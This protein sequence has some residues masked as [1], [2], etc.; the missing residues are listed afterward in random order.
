MFVVVALPRSPCLGRFRRIHL[1]LQIVMLYFSLWFYVIWTFNWVVPIWM[2][3]SRRECLDNFTLSYIAIY[4][5]WCDLSRFLPSRFL[6]FYIDVTCT[7]AKNVIVIN[8]LKKERVIELTIF[9][10]W[11]QSFVIDVAVGIVVGY[12]EIRWLG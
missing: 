8:K 5:S 2:K 7:N 6:L 10:P 4:I 9:G 12:L 3:S 11:N 1:C